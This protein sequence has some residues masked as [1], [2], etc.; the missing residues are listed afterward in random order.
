MFFHIPK[1]GGSSIAWSLRDLISPEKRKNVPEDTSEI[2]WQ[3]AFHINGMHTR[4]DVVS[5]RMARKYQ[6]YKTFCIVR[7]PWDWV[8]SW[9]TAYHRKDSLEQHKKG[10]PLAVPKIL[11]GG[12]KSGLKSQRNQIDYVGHSNGRLAMTQI[13]RF[14]DLENEF[15][16]LMKEFDITDYHELEIKNP[17]NLIHMSYRDVYTDETREMVAE[18]YSRDIKEFGYEF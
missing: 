12:W 4:Y 13:G 14:E 16:R 5:T 15:T 11:Y 1:T 18:H 7:N 6:G 3:G 9:Y 8:L 2:G 10:F 17:S